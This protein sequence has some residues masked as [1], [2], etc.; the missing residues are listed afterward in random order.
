MPKKCYYNQKIS[1]ARL[2]YESQKAVR[3]ICHYQKD[4]FSVREEDC[5]KHYRIRRLDQGGYFITRRRPFNT[6]QDLIA[7]YTNS[8]DGLCVRLDKACAKCDAPQ[9][10]TFTHGKSTRFGQV[11]GCEFE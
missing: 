3:M 10:F 6:L 7:H 5:V 4:C 2:W 11:C 1:T 9:T 8:A